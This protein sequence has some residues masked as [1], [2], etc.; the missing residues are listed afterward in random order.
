MS[1]TLCCS[2]GQ[3]ALQASELILMCTV[4]KNVQQSASKFQDTPE[5]S[6]RKKAREKTLVCCDQGV[7]GWFVANVK[8]S[9]V[10]CARA[11][12]KKHVH[13]YFKNSTGGYARVAG[14]ACTLGAA[15]GPCC[16]AQ[17][18]NSL[19]TRFAISVGALRGWWIEVPAS[20]H[21]LHHCRHQLGRC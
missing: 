10:S 15:H 20:A 12:R 7:F 19:S 1:L 11:A 6:G 13:C 21:V 4:P 16:A 17:R 18:H 2:G 3:F 5:R 14:S 9:K 8:V